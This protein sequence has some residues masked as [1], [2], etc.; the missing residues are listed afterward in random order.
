MTY[1]SALRDLAPLSLSIVAIALFIVMGSMAPAEP[2]ADGPSPPVADAG[3][4]LVVPA[5]EEVVLDGTGS[6]ANEGIARW[7]WTI[8]HSEGNM[9]LEGAQVP[10]AF[11]SPGTYAIVLRVTDGNGVWSTDS[12]L[13]TVL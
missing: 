12:M 4:D 5:G 1:E 10:F 7:D 8:A 11:A 6:T 13:V 2:V 3:P 9:T